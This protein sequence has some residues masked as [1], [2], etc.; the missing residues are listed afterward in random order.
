[1]LFFYFPAFII[2]GEDDLDGII[3]LFDGQKQYPTPKVTVDFTFVEHTEY[4]CIEIIAICIPFE[5]FHANKNEKNDH[6]IENKIDKIENKIDQKLENKNK[7][8]SE[9]KLQFWKRKK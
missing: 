9:I 7:N 3:I 5:I 1:M 8:E 2:L 4:D 6:K